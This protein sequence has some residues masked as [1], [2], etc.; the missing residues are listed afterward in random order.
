MRSCADVWKCCKDLV[1]GSVRILCQ[2]LNIRLNFLI[3]L[4]TAIATSNSHCVAVCFRIYTLI[5]LELTELKNYRI[6]YYSYSGHVIFCSLFECEYAIS[7]KSDLQIDNPSSD[8]LPL[9][10]PRQQSD[11]VLLRHLLNEAI[12]L[13]FICVKDKMYQDSC[14]M[15]VSFFL[16]V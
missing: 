5:N 13:P 7:W 8:R 9:I 14:L 2:T 15:V 3:D 10:H 4:I 6:R 16:S 1:T 11:Q 12:W